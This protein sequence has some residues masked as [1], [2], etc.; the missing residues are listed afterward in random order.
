MKIDDK[1]AVAKILLMGRLWRDGLRV[2]FFFFKW[3]KYY[4]IDC[5]DDCTIL[6]IHQ[7]ISDC[8]CMSEM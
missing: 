7:K 4:K 6:Q 1:L 8:K 2:S 3:Y 5:G